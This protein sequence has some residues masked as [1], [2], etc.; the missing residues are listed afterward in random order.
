MW[1]Y[2]KINK[3]PLL[4][5]IRVPLSISKGYQ[6]SYQYNIVTVLSQPLF[7]NQFNNHTVTSSGELRKCNIMFGAIEHCLLPCSL[8][9]VHMCLDLCT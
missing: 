4:K 8:I 6:Y 2:F 3:I 5:S 9:Y 1:E 7:N